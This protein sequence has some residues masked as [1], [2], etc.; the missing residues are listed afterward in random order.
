MLYCIAYVTDLMR[1][2]WDKFEKNHQKW[3]L[4]SYLGF[5]LKNL[6]DTFFLDWQKMKKNCHKLY[7]SIYRYQLS[8]LAEKWKIISV[9]YRYRPIRKLN[10]SVQSNISLIWH[11]TILS[12]DRENSLL[13]FVQTHQKNIWSHHFWFFAKKCQKYRS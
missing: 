10:L 7:I 6:N 2:I 9:F 11:C 8:V 1:K 4:G 12:Q 3:D 5:F 13:L